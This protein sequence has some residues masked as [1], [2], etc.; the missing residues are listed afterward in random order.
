LSCT[1]VVHGHGVDLF[2]HTPRFRA[3]FF[4]DTKRQRG[5]IN[6]IWLII[7]FREAMDHEK[8]YIC[9]VSFGGCLVSGF[10]AVWLRFK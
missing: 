2:F 3:N 9:T 8:K 4:I 6:K 7:K 10:Y 5:I 1:L